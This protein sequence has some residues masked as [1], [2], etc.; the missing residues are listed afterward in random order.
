MEN[1]CLNRALFG[2]VNLKNKLSWPARLR[3]RTGM[4]RGLL[5][6]HDVNSKMKIVHRDIKL[7]NIL[8][9]KDLNPKISDFGL[10]MYYNRAITHIKTGLAG[11]V[12][13]MAPE[14]VIRGT[15]IEKIDIYSFGIVTL[16]LMTGKNRIQWKTKHESIS[17]LDLACDLQQRGD[18]LGLFDQDVRMN[19]P[20]K[21]AEMV[22]NLAILCTNYDP[23]LRPT[24]SEVV[25]TSA[26]LC[27]N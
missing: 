7:S 10:T 4:A 1:G 20:V 22:L 18:L 27:S 3:I 23:K 26:I 9:D 8:L 21:E 16:Q 14:Y 17:L 15:V 25:D 6:L 12:G 19:I 24:M 11:T 13:Y 2:P 5:Y